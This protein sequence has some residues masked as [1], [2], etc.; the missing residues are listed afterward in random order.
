MTAVTNLKSANVTAQDAI[1]IYGRLLWLSDP[2]R[3]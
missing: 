2:Q 3:W 1:A